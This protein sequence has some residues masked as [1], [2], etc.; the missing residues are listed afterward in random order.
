MTCVLNFTHKKFLELSLCLP[1]PT[2]SH[3]N[4]FDGRRHM[5]SGL[6]RCAH[7]ILS[8]FHDL[9]TEPSAHGVGLHVTLLHHFPHHRQAAT[10]FHFFQIGRRVRRRR[11]QWKNTLKKG[12]IKPPPHHRLL[13]GTQGAAQFFSNRCPQAAHLNFFG[14]ERPSHFNIFYLTLL[15][16]IPLCQTSTYLTLNEHLHTWLVGSR[17]SV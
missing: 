17:V 6:Q 14:S 4:I 1:T 8:D 7:H 9:C 13:H 5:A 10:Q 15:R 16:I 3:L 12:E 2:P 11:S